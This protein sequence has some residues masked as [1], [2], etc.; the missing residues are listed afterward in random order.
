MASF[1]I[2]PLGEGGRS[3]SGIRG[4]MVNAVDAP[5]ART[6]ANTFR[7]SGSD[8]DFTNAQL[9][10]AAQVNATDSTAEFLIEG[11]PIAFGVVRRGH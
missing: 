3:A 9:W 8:P 11:A 2:Y 6:R 1:C 7:V 10:G 4:A 5:T